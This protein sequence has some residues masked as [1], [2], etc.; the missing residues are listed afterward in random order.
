M[1]RLG[2]ALTFT[3]AWICLIVG[4]ALCI[5]SQISE[6]IVRH[7]ALESVEKIKESCK[8]KFE[9]V[10]EEQTNIL[11]QMI[12]RPEVRDALSVLFSQRSGPKEI[13][14]LA[15]SFN[16]AVVKDF[17]C[18][19]DQGEVVY[20]LNNTFAVG[21][22]CH[23]IRS[24]AELTERLPI[25]LVPAVADPSLLPGTSEPLIAMGFPFIHNKQ[26]RGSLVLLLNEKVFKEILVPYRG[27][28]IV[29]VAMASG[30]HGNM[31]FSTDEKTRFNSSF[32]TER[33]P[34]NRS[35]PLNCGCLIGRVFKGDFTAA[36]E[37]VDNK[38][39][40]NAQTFLIQPRWALVA[41]QDKTTSMQLIMV[42]M[43]LGILFIAVGV[44]L[45]ILWLVTHIVRDVTWFIAHRQIIVLVLL[46]IGFLFSITFLC[47]YVK[48]YLDERG[49][50]Y[51]ANVATAQKDL[52]Y[53]ASLLVEHNY[54]LQAVVHR[55]A[56]DFQE[57]QVSLKNWPQLSTQTIKIL[58]KASTS[59]FGI[60]YMPLDS[61]S[62][63][64]WNTR[65]I[66]SRPD[67]SLKEGVIEQI[68]FGDLLKTTTQATWIRR[69]Q[70]KE[71]NPSVCFLYVE[72]F[73][74]QNSG[75][76]GF[77]WGMVAYDFV[78]D[79]IEVLGQDT[80]L[81]SVS[82]D[83]NGILIYHKELDLV[84]DSVKLSA[85]NPD[86]EPAITKA[87][88]GFS[89]VYE[90]PEEK[91]LFVYESM[92]SYIGSSASQTRW[93]VGAFYPL[94]SFYTITP[95]LKQISAGIL[96]LLVLALVT[97]IALAVNL[98][99]MSL[100]SFIWFNPLYFVTL[101]VGIVGLIVLNYRYYD[102][103]YGSQAIRSKMSTVRFEEHLEA[104]L[105]KGI[106]PL[107]TSITIDYLD[108]VN[109]NKVTFSATVRQTVD[110]TVGPQVKLGIE[111]VNRSDKIS[112]KEIGRTMHES[113]ESVVYRIEGAVH[114]INPVYSRTPFDTQPIAL[115]M[116]PAD[117]S[118]P[119]A[120]VL[121]FEAY[122][123]I[124]P[125]QK[126]GVNTT[127]T[128]KDYV[129]E[130]SYFTYTYGEKPL[131]S[132]V[133]LTKRNLLSILLE[134]FLPLLA[135]L[136]TIFIMSLMSSMTFEPNRRITF[137]TAITGLL[138][139]LIL[140][141][142]KYRT[143]LIIPTFSFL[144]ALIL[145]VYISLGYGY[146]DILWL[147]GKDYLRPYKILFYWPAL[148]T[149]LFAVTVYTFAGA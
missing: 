64:T 57:Q 41:V 49:K 2:K 112:T 42:L 33:Y 12:A 137:V 37:W 105:G 13:K 87:L 93:S 43:W 29:K 80:A 58:S 138:F 102:Y 20:A 101:I 118:N 69:V 36:L 72:P 110:R 129:I 147:L 14:T 98:F 22:S 61:S 44:I 139:A 35:D 84:R 119:V 142:Q 81:N 50:T 128:M 59:G 10:F 88:Q 95:R 8:Q 67:G 68:S 4:L 56:H 25:V 106:I 46:G 65:Y 3:A 124:N 140:L 134:Y 144:E 85:I 40:C 94:S 17:L 60:S 103:S 62:T 74:A 116:A 130:K 28:A 27:A 148:M 99:E 145:A 132:F 120:L 51:R 149:Y 66:V 107:K 79:I 123:Q 83:A 24:L 143:S 71:L 114:Q 133:M 97:G 5:G 73:V 127:F 9:H 104:A 125:S 89:G 19:N 78:K 109:P 47:S 96:I 31:L 45:L 90:L 53:A 39:R 126:P 7:S 55:V 30:E 15:Q 141:H 91:S 18:I 115:L 131:L 63:D 38:W 16:L 6:K 77:I 76:R 54:H 1:A 48:K 111:F 34:S 117:H 113:V 52:Q 86:L 21:T 70:Q 136:I 82:F 75:I 146:I 32:L 23:Q 135:I 26:Y 121:D 100:R 11:E 108:I 122:P 92:P